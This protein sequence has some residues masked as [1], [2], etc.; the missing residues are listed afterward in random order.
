MAKSRNK[1]TLAQ[2]DYFFDVYPDKGEIYWKTHEGV[3]PP[4][5]GKLAGSIIFSRDKKAKNP[6]RRTGYRRIWLNNKTYAAHCIIWTKV[7]GKWPDFEIDHKN[8][9]GLDNKINNLRPADTS[10]NKQFSR[11]R[12][13]NSTG[14]KWVSKSPE[15]PGHTPDW[16][17]HVTIKRKQRINKHFH[18]PESAYAWAWTKAW[19]YHGE[20]FHHGFELGEYPL[21]PMDII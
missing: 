3:N 7:K 12:R 2:I 18:N 16:V 17:A 10:K 4:S 9:D 8:W 19:K 13:D 1:L 20:F 14:L 11:I 6:I 5:W 15:P 21:H